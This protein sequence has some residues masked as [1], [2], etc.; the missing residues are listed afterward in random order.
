ML[1]K[2]NNCV[3]IN[4]DVA[5]KVRSFGEGNATIASKTFSKIKSLLKMKKKSLAEVIKP[6]LDEGH[7]INI[8]NMKAFLFVTFTLPDYEI[9]NLIDLLDKDGNGFIPMQDIQKAVEFAKD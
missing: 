5:Y 7:V 1:S 2:S 3:Y 9:E 8:R 4:F 6:F